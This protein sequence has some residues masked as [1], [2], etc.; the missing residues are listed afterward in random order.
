[1]HYHACKERTCFVINNNPEEVQS[2]AL[3]EWK[4]VQRKFSWDILFLLGAGY[5]I[6]DAC[7]ASCLTVWI[8]Q[9]MAGL[10]VFPPF[11]IMIMVSLL[12]T[13]MTEIACNTA[14]ASIL[15]PIVAQMVINIYIRKTISKSLNCKLAY[16]FQGTAI[17]INPMRLMIPVTI[18][19]CNAF[20]LPIGTPSNAM[21]FKA[22]NMKLR[23]MVRN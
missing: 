21:V 2:P 3:L 7:Y 8:G 12:A 6:S 11:V 22:A 13:F 5:A 15:L 23:D 16:Y 18:S 10:N 20:M 4:D 14:T 9:Q 19:S 17:G 1:M